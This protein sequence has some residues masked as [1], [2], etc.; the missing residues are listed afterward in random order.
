MAAGDSME[1]GVS[2]NSIH[3]TF[4]QEAREYYK[5]AKP[6]LVEGLGQNT[7]HSSFHILGSSGFCHSVKRY[8]GVLRS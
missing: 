1:E 4:L 8:R 6:W 5:N 7:Q 3:L 2:R